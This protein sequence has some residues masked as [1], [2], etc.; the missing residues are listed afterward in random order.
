VSLTEKGILRRLV[1]LEG[2][3]TSAERQGRRETKE[4]RKKAEM[5]MNREREGQR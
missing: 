2:I 5:M 3:K 1:K 4:Y